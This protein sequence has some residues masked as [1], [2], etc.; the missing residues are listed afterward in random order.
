MAYPVLV[1]TY[2]PINTS[3]DQSVAQLINNYNPDNVPDDKIIHTDS[4]SNKSISF[5]GL[6]EQA[7]RCAW[8][9]VHKLKLE[10]GKR[11]LAILPNSSDFILL[12]HSVW[13]AGAVFAPLNPSSLSKDVVYALGIVEPA[14]IACDIACL[15]TVSAA[16]ASYQPAQG[17]PE[18][19][20]LRG[21]KHDLPVFPDDIIGRSSSESMT[22]YSLNGKKASE[23]TSTICFSSGTTGMI[24]GVQLS[25]HNIVSNVL[26]MRASLPGILNASHREVFFL[27]YYHIYGLSCVAIYGMWIGSFTY[28]LTSFHLELFCQKLAEHK[29]TFAHLVPPVAAL[30]ATSEIPLKHDLSALTTLVV[31]A[32]P[33]KR[34]LQLKLKAQLGSKIKILQGYGLSECSP[35][36][37]YQHESDE[38]Y[39]GT[40]GKLLSGTQARLVDPNTN[41]DVAKGEEGELW[42]RGPQVM[43]GYVG[44][45][46]ATRNTFSEDGQW[47]RTGD[48]LKVDLNGNFWVTDRLKE[49]IKYKGFQVPP[50][51][52]E[53]LLLRH[54]HVIDAAVCSI[55]D[56]A[57]ATELPL[58]YVSLTPQLLTLGR[59]QRDVLLR[60]IQDW[61]N[62]QVVG[63]KRIR[64]GVFHLQD[65][66]KT[67]TG[68]ILRKNLPAKQCK[69]NDSKL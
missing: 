39:V 52:L 66:P 7:A 64:G 45:E 49:L 50:S 34:D 63:Y 19:L 26:Q 21:R 68:K 32:A 44:D 55:Y 10:E 12:A 15:A 35:T 25:H 8:G 24:K 54:P 27:P 23:T 2:P 59:A 20:L 62:G 30:L 29:A 1:S 22:P 5:G 47:L 4:L 56:D 65:L 37:M 31:A 42:V 53:D 51:E 67:P 14:Y 17:R 11:V 60:E 18:I 38:N 36:V 43:Q 33:M 9:L 48:I 40:A 16:L 57:Q 61:A 41:K 13:W 28:G 3:D 6:R 58:A 69:T 46:Q